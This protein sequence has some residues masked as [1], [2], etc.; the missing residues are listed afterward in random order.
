MKELQ[1]I[2]VGFIT[3]QNATTKMNIVN[4]VQKISQIF[5]YSVAEIV[6]KKQVRKEKLKL[7]LTF[8]AWQSRASIKR[9]GQNFY[10]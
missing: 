4:M 9:M 7:D 5:F 1:F 2:G 10:T 3:T 6:W 8:S